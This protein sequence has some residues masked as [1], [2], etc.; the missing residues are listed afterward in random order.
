MIQIFIIRLIAE[1]MSKKHTVHT[2]FMDEE[3]RILIEIVE[4]DK[5]G[6]WGWWRKLTEAGSVGIVLTGTVEQV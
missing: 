4:C 6:L 2:A 5:L 3:K 1:K